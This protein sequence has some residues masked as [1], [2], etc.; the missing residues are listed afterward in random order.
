M[1]PAKTPSRKTASPRK[2]R[3]PKS[4]STAETKKAS[5]ALQKVLANGTSDAD[6]HSAGS[7]KVE[8]NSAVE[9]HDDIE[10]TRTQ[11]KVELP[12]G[13]AEFPIPETTEQMI[14]K[15]KEMVAEAHKLEDGAA[16]TTKKGT[17]RK[18]AAAVES[19]EQEKAEQQ[20]RTKK[21][22]IE[23]EQQREKVKTRALIGV[24]ATL[25]LG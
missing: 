14:E 25:A 9:T 17:K 3:E 11:V 5:S 20:S 24:S 18:A 15:A 1:S 12:A 21:P 16:E 2:T 13:L 7:V 19:D 22:K 8:V 4:V 6:G 23:E 10:T